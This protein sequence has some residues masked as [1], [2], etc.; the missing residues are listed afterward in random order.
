MAPFFCVGYSYGTGMS[1]WYGAAGQL[2]LC[3]CAKLHTIEDHVMWHATV[4]SS[5]NVFKPR[6]LGVCTLY[7]LLDS[8]FNVYTVYCMF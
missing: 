4:V 2:H 6:N 3:D 7:S 8:L 1:A 5:T